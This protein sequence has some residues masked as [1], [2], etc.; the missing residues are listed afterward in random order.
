[1]FLLK[2]ND[3]M[4]VTLPQSAVETLKDIINDNQDRPKTIRVYFAGTACSGP[5]FGLALDD[6]AQDDVF[7]ETE[8]LS[9]VMN[10]A[11]YEQYGDILI[12]DTGYGFR[13]IPENM[14]DQGGCGGGC[15]GCG[16]GH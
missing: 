3:K 6:M 5:S 8:G 1:M 14:K 4:K 12:E 7:C 13:V 11:E 15:S 9:F 16:C 2:G 10:K